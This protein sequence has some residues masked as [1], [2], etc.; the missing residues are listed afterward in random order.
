LFSRLV[1]TDGKTL[2]ELAHA[3]RIITSARARDLT[4][5]MSS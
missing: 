4:V 3:A 1:V 5:L 2:A